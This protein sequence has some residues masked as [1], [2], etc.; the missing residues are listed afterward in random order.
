MRKDVRNVYIIAAIM[1]LVLYSAG[2]F[3]GFF[4]EQ[5]VIARTEERV[6]ALQRRLENVQLEYM[7]LSTMGTEVKCDFLSVLV[8]DTTK[9]VWDIGQELVSLQ[10]QNSQEKVDELAKDY[11]LLSVRA[12]ILNSYV[13]EKCKENKVTLL[14]FYSVPCKSCIE[15]GKILDEL[16]EKTF[17]NKIRIFVLNVNYDETIVQILKKTYNITETPSIVIG[18]ST[19]TG[20]TDKEKLS[21]I[22]EKHLK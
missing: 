22:I 14:Y 20:L 11:S 8:D 2:M 21:E 1:S 4:V 9:E 3:T 13:N 18:S 7:Y 12:W 16:R 19:Y 5:S 10:G 17:Q 15:Q 6:K